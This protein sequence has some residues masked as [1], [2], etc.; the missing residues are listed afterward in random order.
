MEPNDRRALDRM[1]AAATAL[2]KELSEICCAHGISD[3]FGYDIYTVLHAL[4]TLTV[5]FCL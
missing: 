4:R 1:N 3:E 5:R 2:S